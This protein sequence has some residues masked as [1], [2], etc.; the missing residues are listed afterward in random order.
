LLKGRLGLLL[1]RTV[2]EGRDPA[3]GGEK[4]PLPRL[5]NLANEPRKAEPP[6]SG[7]GVKH[8][9]E[10]GLQ[11]DR[12]RMAGQINRAFAQTVHLKCLETLL[13][14]DDKA[15]SLDKR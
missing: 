14:R 1:L 15:S 9:P 3:G 5:I 6:A 7:H 8:R 12:C 10:L 11:R 4:T 13:D 2:S